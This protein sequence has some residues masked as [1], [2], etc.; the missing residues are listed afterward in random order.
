MPA[1]SPDVNAPSAADA[2][3]ITRQFD[4]KQRTYS[5]HDLKEILD[6]SESGVDRL[7]ADGGL[8][9]FRVGERGVK[10]TRVA[11]VDYLLRTGRHTPKPPVPAPATSSTK[12]LRRKG[13]RPRKRNPV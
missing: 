3:E 5:R 7:L 2:A 11:L 6:L 8:P 4:L 9:S 13:G 1:P 12:P 10:V